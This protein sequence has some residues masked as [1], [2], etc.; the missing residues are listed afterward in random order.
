MLDL[1]G[2][3]LTTNRAYNLHYHD[4]A[5]AVK[6]WRDLAAAEGS[7]CENVWKIKNGDNC[8]PCEIVARPVSPKFTRQDTGAAMPTVKAIVD[9]FVDAGFWPDDS[10]DWIRQISFQ[11]QQRD[12][13]WKRP[14]IRIWVFRLAQRRVD[15]AVL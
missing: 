7:K 15:L 9:G 1:M 12:R 8:S 3:V 4:R 6:Y 10:P 14:G 13:S 11:P 2:Q 5:K